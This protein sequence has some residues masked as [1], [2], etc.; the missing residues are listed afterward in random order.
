MNGRREQLAKT[1]VSMVVARQASDRIETLARL[2]GAAALLANSLSK[3]LNT[4]FN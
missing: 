2:A 3:L 4:L 1:R